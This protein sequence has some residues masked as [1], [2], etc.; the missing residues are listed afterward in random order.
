M[1]GIHD[2]G[3]V[4]VPKEREVSLVEEV[5]VDK[6]NILA[7]HIDIPIDSVPQLFVPYKEVMDIYE[8]GLEVPEHVTLVW[9]DDNYGYMKRLSDKEEQKRKG[10]AGVYYHISYC[11]EPHDYLWLN[12]TPPTLMYEELSKAYDTGADRY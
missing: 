9:P 4:G 1:R 11:G 12:T 5:L 10:G 7:K 6:R 3:L 8:C 2:L